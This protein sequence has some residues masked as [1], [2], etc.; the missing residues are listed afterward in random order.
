MPRNNYPG[1]KPQASK[2]RRDAT[3]TGARDVTFPTP[4]SATRP[5]GN[6]SSSRPE[7]GT[8]T[9]T[10][11]GRQRQLRVH[12]IRR[13]QADVGKIARAVI[14]MALA[15]AEKDPAEGDGHDAA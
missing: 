14:A 8:K 1:G 9:R 5:S 3:V 2:R 7:S 4:A 12:S 10:R 13:D 15:Q 11:R 6:R